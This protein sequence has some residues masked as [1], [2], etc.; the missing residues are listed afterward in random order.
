M[1]TPSSCDDNLI[2]VTNNCETLP[3]EISNLIAKY[4]CKR[5]RRSFIRVKKN[6]FSR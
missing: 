6:S 5:S 4:Y 1:K 3:V 2:Q